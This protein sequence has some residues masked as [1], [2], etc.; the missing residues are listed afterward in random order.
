MKKLIAFLFVTVAAF[1]QSAPAAKPAHTNKPAAAPAPITT[2]LRLE[3]ARTQRD[4]MIAKSNMKSAA[5][6]HSQNKS[7]SQELTSKLT[8]QLAEAQKSCKAEEV[9]DGETL[10]CVPRPAE[11]KK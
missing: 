5:E 8:E 4:I 9:F 3:I 6:F 2:E 10:G 1:A 11:P 7:R